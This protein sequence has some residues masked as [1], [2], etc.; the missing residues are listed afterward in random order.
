MLGHV[1][2]GFAAQELTKKW[3]SVGSDSLREVKH[4]ALAKI[5][6]GF[7]ASRNQGLDDPLGYEA[8]RPMPQPPPYD[9]GP[10]IL[11]RP[12]PVAQ[13]KPCQPFPD[14]RCVSS[15]PSSPSIYPATLPLAGDN[16]SEYQ[17]L[18]PD[19]TADQKSMAFSNQSHN[20]GA[21]AK[22]LASYEVPT[23]PGTYTM[24]Q[25]NPEDDQSRTAV[26]STAPPSDKP[27]SA[28]P[29]LIPP[30]SSL[31]RSMSM[32]TM[33]YVSFSI[34]PDPHRSNRG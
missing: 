27:F 26:S 2:S 4:P 19:S 22:K 34:P 10:A 7:A 11:N 1:G 23:N 20:R 13:P 18:S 16:C 5:S 31:R 21:S 24:T 6:H 17:L 9:K 29:P 15:T 25:L 32:R 14:W 8:Y 12:L 28:H 30:K 33:F 3:P